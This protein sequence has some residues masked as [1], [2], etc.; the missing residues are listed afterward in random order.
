MAKTGSLSAI[1]RKLLIIPL[2][3]GLVFG[4]LPLIPPLFA[5]LFGFSGNDGYIYQLAGAATIGYAYPLFIAIKG[6]AW[7]EIRFVIKAT[8]AFNLLSLYA[9]ARALLTPGEARPVVYLITVTSIAIVFLTGSLLKK[10]GIGKVSG[11]GDIAGWVTIIL[12]LATLSAAV[13]GIFPL[14][15]KAFAAFFGYRGTDA[16][17]FREAGAACFGYAVMGIYELMSKKFSEIRIPLLM[18]G[19][20]NGVAL[21][22]SL[23]ALAS[24]QNTLLVYVVAAATL[25]F[26]PGLFGAYLR[27]GK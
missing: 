2:A 12:A 7:D 21:V 3:G 18:G 17:I 6:A 14:F 23:L 16:F 19:I 4:I 1:E 22:V 11:K 5:S 15:P 24:G 10:Y 27:K 26:T 9:C 20:F 13:F 8:F 25:V